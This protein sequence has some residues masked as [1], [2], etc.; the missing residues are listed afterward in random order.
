MEWVARQ[1]MVLVVERELVRL[2][3]D[4]VREH[5]EEIARLQARQAGVS[6]EDI[7]SAQQ[8]VNSWLVE[9]KEGSGGLN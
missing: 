2:K 4:V 5:Q 7:H 9:R 3:A 8:E 1:G 6:V